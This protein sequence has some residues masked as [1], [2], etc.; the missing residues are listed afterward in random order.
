[1][2]SARFKGECLNRPER[3]VQEE[4]IMSVKEWGQADLDLFLK[5]IFAK[6]K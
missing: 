3:I 1:M 4:E 2:T 5:M 6:D